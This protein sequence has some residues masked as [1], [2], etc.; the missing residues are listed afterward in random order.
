MALIHYHSSL[1]RILIKQV[2]ILRN[3]LT[4]DDKRGKFDN[5]PFAIG[6]VDTSII[7][8]RTS[9]DNVKQR[10]YGNLERILTF[11][12]RITF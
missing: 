5:H 7:R 4:E 12:L 11:S 1:F 9:S 10:K 6:S 2:E 8:I 3:N